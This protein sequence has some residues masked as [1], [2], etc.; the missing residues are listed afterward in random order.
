MSNLNEL[1]P[2][3]NLSPFARFCC[4]IGNL[5]SS[6]MVSLTYEEQLLWL[7]DYLKN[8][9]IPAV[10]TNAEAVKELQELYV[11][12]KDYVDNYFN[13]LDVQ[14]E[15]NNKL[16]KMA[17]SGELTEI[18]AH[19]LQLQGILAFNSKNDLKNATNLVNGSFT[20]T[21]GDI[22][23]NDG[24][25]NFYKIRTLLSSD[26]IDD[27]N[28]ISLNNFPT[29]IAEK[30]VSY[31][32][33]LLNNNINLIN[34]KLFN[35][36]TKNK[37]AYN[38]NLDFIGNNLSCSLEVLA[39]GSASHSIQ[40]IAYDKLNARI[41]C[42]NET[43]IYEISKNKETKTLFTGNYGHGGD[44]AIL[45]NFLFISDSLENKIYKVNLQ[46][47]N[48][49]IFEI[50][51]TKIPNSAKLGGICFDYSPNYCYLAFIIED[52]DHSKVH[53]GNNI[54]LFKYDFKDNLSLLFE[55]H[56][57]IVFIQGLTCDNDAFYI[58]GNIPFTSNYLGN[59][60]YI[61]NKLSFNI[62]DTLFNNSELEFEGI[63][64]ACIDGVEGLLCELGNFGSISQFAIFA[65]YG[66][67][68]ANKIIKS[69]NLEIYITY[70]N[71]L[72]NVHCSITNL[73]IAKGSNYTI[74]NFFDN[75]FT[76]KFT[77]GDLPYITVGFGQSRSVRALVEYKG[78]TDSL[79]IRTDD[80]NSTNMT[81]INF[82]FNFFGV[83]I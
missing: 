20:K 12:L 65:F 40:G 26:V 70:K 53:E 29:L 41:I 32:E 47:G 36:F 79:Y 7:C 27:I 37:N 75:I 54:F 76:K 25:G 63:D 18:I 67:T 13:N 78:V 43:E 69:D 31:S 44:C 24:Y 17:E 39:N 45:N 28:I 60:L 68:I 4:T 16:D 46:N 33:L 42:N 38:K 9:V 49:Q 77:T 21:F 30:I 50:D 19:Y 22:S 23:Y 61:I 35:K 10:N 3:G 58:A 1:K 59:N 15:I 66:N 81:S 80:S 2:V 72:L 51:N 8:T 6:Y 48:T 71:N 74:N 14:N 11:K 56:L 52:N 57:D 73:D 5:P 55:K 83:M 64:Y 62:V 82:T 34:N